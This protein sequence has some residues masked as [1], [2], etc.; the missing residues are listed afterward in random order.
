MTGDPKSYQDRLACAFKWTFSCLIFSD[1]IKYKSE[2]AP[3]NGG[4]RLSGLLYLHLLSGRGLR[5]GGRTR[6]IRDLYCVVEVDHIHKAR[7]V[8]R[9]GGINFDWGER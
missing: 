2:A 9:S 3:E 4:L 7:T 8:V 1:F 6:R 5:T